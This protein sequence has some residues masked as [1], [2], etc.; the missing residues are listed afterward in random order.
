MLYT[1]IY[2]K[3]CI[4]I[5]LLILIG[6]SSPKKVLTEELRTFERVCKEEGKGGKKEGKD[7]GRERGRKVL[8]KERTWSNYPDI[9]PG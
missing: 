4:K 2:K 6:D 8:T 1:S 9:P 7:R 3:V 5:G